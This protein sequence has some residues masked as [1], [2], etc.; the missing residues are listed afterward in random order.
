MSLYI[1]CTSLSKRQESGEEMTVVFAN[2]TYYRVEESLIDLP[3]FS[4]NPS[5]Y[6]VMISFYFK[7]NSR[8][9]VLHIFAMHNTVQISIANKCVGTAH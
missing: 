1:K 9:I 6:P 4:N 3:A 5:P 7:Y 2:V 8:R